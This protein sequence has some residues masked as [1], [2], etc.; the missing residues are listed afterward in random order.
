MTLTEIRGLLSCTG[1]MIAAMATLNEKKVRA[2][3]M[4][5]EAIWEDVDK[6]KAAKNA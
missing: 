4:R 5:V 6:R 1:A 2:V 3:A